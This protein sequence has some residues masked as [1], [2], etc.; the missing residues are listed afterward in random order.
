MQLEFLRNYASMSR[1][2]VSAVAENL[3]LYTD[4]FSTF[5]AVFPNAICPSNPWIS[6]DMSYWILN[7]PM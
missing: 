3:M 4:E 6:D 7:Q 2:K 1:S 5:D